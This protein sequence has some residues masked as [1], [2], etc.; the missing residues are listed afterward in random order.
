MLANPGSEDTALRMKFY[1]LIPSLSSLLSSWGS[2]LRGAHCEQPSPQRYT[3]S[4]RNG[5]S[6]K[7]VSRLHC[8]ASQPKP[9]ATVGTVPKH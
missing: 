9:R 6:V 5:F 4:S 1:C 2:V 7:S 3:E 8:H